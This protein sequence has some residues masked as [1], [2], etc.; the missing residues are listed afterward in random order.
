MDGRSL[1]KPVTKSSREG[2]CERPRVTSDLS[3][4]LP[5]ACVSNERG[6]PGNQLLFTIEV[7]HAKTS[8]AGFVNLL[9]PT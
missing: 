2:S 3:G 4:M 1:L 5:E 6:H 9:N 7:P 8:T